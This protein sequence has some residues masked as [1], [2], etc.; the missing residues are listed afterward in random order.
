VIDGTLRLA[1][2]L[3]GFVVHDNSGAGQRVSLR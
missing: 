2:H 3:E 1:D